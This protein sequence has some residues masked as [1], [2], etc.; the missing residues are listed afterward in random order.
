MD[1]RTY[2]K[3]PVDIQA[4]RVT[5][6][7]AAEV[8]AWAGGEVVETED[9]IEVVVIHTLEGDMV[10]VAGVWVAQGVAGEFYSIQPDIFTVLYVEAAQ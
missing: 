6:E 2:T 3:R 5:A 4:V 9:G 8:A 10:A 7:N 1:V